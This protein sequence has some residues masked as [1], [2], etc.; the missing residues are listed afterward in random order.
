MSDK[1]RTIQKNMIWPPALSTFI[2][3]KTC[4]L[5]KKG[6]LKGADFD[7]AVGKTTQKEKLWRDQETWA[8]KWFHEEREAALVLFTGEQLPPE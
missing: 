4:Q 2:L 1:Y 8:P 7:L 3:D 6:V 5:I